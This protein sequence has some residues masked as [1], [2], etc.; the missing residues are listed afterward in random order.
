MIPIAMLEEFGRLTFIS[1][2]EVRNMIANS[3]KSI[4]LL[5][6][7]TIRRTARIISM[8]TKTTTKMTMT[9][10]MMMIMM[11][12]IL[13]LDTFVLY[14][15]GFYITSNIISMCYFQTNKSI[16]TTNVKQL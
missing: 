14:N 12:L 13:L 7:Y 15:V 6:V 9:T 16:K 8:Q 10:Q 3:S 4:K 2:V 11:L 5:I 1:C